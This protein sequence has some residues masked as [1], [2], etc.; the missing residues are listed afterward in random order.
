MFRRKPTFTVKYVE[1]RV[2]VSEHRPMLPVRIGPRDR[3]TLTYNLDIDPKLLTLMRR[4]DF[5]IYLWEMVRD[6][7]MELYDA[8]QVE[9]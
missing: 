7:A 5:R 1:P 8:L 9:R 6:K 4:E 3:V 2:E